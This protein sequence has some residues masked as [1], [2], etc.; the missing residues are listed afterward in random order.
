MKT[1]LFSL[2]LL[3]SLLVTVFV[4]G[5]FAQDLDRTDAQEK[6]IYPKFA[7]IEWESSPETVR[8]VIL[9]HFGVEPE[10]YPDYPEGKAYLGKGIYG[11]YAKISL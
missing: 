8:K 11:E 1:K 2:F 7:D 3:V 9:E 6:S 10:P 5:S 4:D